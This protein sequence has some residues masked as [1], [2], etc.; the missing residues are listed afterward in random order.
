[1]EF[2]VKLSTQWN[3]IKTDCLIIPVADSKTLSPLLKDID[4]ASGKLISTLLKS[5]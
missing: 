4:K 3:T 1:M 2:A 5:G